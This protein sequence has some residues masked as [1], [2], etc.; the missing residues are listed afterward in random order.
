MS[1]ISRVSRSLSRTMMA[2]NCWR[3]ARSSS[4]SS[5]RVSDK[6]RIEVSG[7]RSSWLTLLTN[8]PFSRSGCCSVALACRNSSAVASS[9]RDFFYSTPNAAISSAAPRATPLPAAGP[10]SGDSM[11]SRLDDTARN[12]SAI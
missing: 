3:C 2:R 4:G 7:V 12:C 6:E 1:V 10:P 8:S 5:N 9:S 11:T